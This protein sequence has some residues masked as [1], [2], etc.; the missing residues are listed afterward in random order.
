MID[1]AGNFASVEP[2][3]SYRLCVYTPAREL[4]ATAARSLANLYC[5]GSSSS[6]QQQKRA[7][8]DE[9]AQEQQHQQWRSDL[10]LLQQHEEQLLQQ[11]SFLSLDDPEVPVAVATAA[12]HLAEMKHAVADPAPSAAWVEEVFVR[13]P[14]SFLCLL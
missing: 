8:G 11:L 14:L 3:L 12:K 4:S 5:G 7:E 13:R 2:T 9:E 1:P 10:Q 6:K